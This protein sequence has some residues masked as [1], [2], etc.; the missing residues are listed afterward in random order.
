MY[1]HVMIIGAHD[2]NYIII[3]WLSAW[4]EKH[5]LHLK[6]NGL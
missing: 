4:V 3:M 6:F 2:E 5:N 1:V